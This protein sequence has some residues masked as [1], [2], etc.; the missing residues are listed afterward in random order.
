MPIARPKQFPSGFLF[1]ALLAASGLLW[2]VMFFGPLT[3]VTH[4]AG[5]MT[6]FDIRP[7]GYSYASEAPPPLKARCAFIAVPIFMTSLDLFENG[8]P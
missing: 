7:K 2:A 1:A 6:P 4:L 8:V 3:H 5:G